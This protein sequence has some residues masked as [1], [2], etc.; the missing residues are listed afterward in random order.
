MPNLSSALPAGVKVTIAGKLSGGNVVLGGN[1]LTLRTYTLPNGANAAHWVF[2]AATI[3][4]LI[5]TI[6]NDKNGVT[7]A[8][9]S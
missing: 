2:P 5:L 3:D 4:T 7:W 9:P 1:A 8:T 6:Y